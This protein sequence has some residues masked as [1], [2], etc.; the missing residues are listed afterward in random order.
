MTATQQ[1]TTT[2]LLAPAVSG[3]R[4]QH[5]AGALTRLLFETAR[6]HAALTAD[7]APYE[8]RQSYGDGSAVRAGLVRRLRRRAR[9][10]RQPGTGRGGRRAPH[11]RGAACRRLRLTAFAPT[12]GRE[13]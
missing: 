4:E 11:G 6:R 9:A 13:P 12:S 10:G 1:D 5:E 3:R 8:C 7:P 2:A